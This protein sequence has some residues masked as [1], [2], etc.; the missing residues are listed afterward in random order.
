MRTRFGL[1]AA[2]VCWLGLVT[3]PVHAT[4]I[5]DIGTA[6]GNTSQ[7]EEFDVKNGVYDNGLQ[8]T[9]ASSKVFTLY[10]YLTNPSAALFNDVYYISAALTPRVFPPGGNFGSFS[11][12][13]ATTDFGYVDKNG[14]NQVTKS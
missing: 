9:V 4:P 12:A 14:Q 8:E 13:N 6:F 10:A 3:T 5:L 11:V 7:P 1:A 2:L